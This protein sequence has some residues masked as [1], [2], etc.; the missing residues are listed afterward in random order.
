MNTAVI[1]QVWLKLLD[2]LGV[3]T[4]E[5]DQVNFMILTRSGVASKLQEFKERYMCFAESLGGSYEFDAEYPAW[6]FKAE[7]KIREITLDAFEHI[8][9]KRPEVTEI[10][11]GL[12]C[13]LLSGHKPELDCISFGPNMI[14]VHSYNER[15]EI[16]SAER[17]WKALKEILKRCK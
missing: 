14:D 3:V 12:E 6:T 7:S 17:I 5:N 9:G 11:A 16:A 4:T 8:Y 2:N 10:H 15:L 1:F 13:G